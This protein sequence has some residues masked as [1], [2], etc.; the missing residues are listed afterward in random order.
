[1]QGDTALG[2]GVL[3]QIARVRGH[4]AR[5]RSP[6]VKRYMCSMGRTKTWQTLTAEALKAMVWPPLDERRKAFPEARTFDWV[7]VHGLGYLDMETELLA[8]G[9]LGLVSMPEPDLQ[10]LLERGRPFLAVTVQK[11]RGQVNDCHGNT[12]RTW[13][14]AK[15]S[16]QVATGFALSDD[17][18]WRQHT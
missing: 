10:Q 11:A 14:E 13:R 8:V 15:G 2:E 5:L 16:L 7:G 17:A 12:A 1:L 9:G 4:A 3:C 18:L 6:P